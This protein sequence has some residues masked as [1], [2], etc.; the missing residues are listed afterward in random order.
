MADGAERMPAVDGELRKQF[1]AAEAIAHIGS[2]EWTIATGEVTWSHEL[3]RIYGLEPGSVAITL[4]F[5]LSRAHPDDRGR[6]EREIQGVLRHPGPF[7][8]REVIVRPD[9]SLRTLDTVGHT[10]ADD[11]GAIAR[12]AGTCRDITDEVARDE[13]LRFYADVFEHA[14]IGLTAWKLDR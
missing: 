4:E 1:E 9:G 8:Y 5:F 11:H 12:V 7:T 3:Y 6:V 13:R 14:E 10:I 2:W